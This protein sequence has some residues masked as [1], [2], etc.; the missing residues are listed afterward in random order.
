MISA[1]SVTSNLTAGWPGRTSRNLRGLGRS[2]N[3][4]KK[5]SSASLLRLHPWR[6]VDCITSSPRLTSTGCPKTSSMTLRVAW[7]F[8]IRWWRRGPLEWT[9]QR[10]WSV[11]FVRQFGVCC[12]YLSVHVLQYV[13]VV[14]QSMSPLFSLNYCMC[15]YLS[16]VL[17]M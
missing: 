14:F 17:L 6:L 1:L 7:S 2:W 15:S 11:V 10:I 3:S 4:L 9:W 8:F 12:L 5:T 13:Q 16:C